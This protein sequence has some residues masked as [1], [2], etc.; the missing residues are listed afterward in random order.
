MNNNKIFDSDNHYYEQE[1]AFTRYVPHSMHD[2]CVKWIYVNNKKRALIGGKLNY[3]IKDPSFEFLAKPGAI[4]KY[5]Y[6]AD[7]NTKTVKDIISSSI[8][9]KNNFSH[10][11][12]LKDKRT[13]IKELN[14][15][16]VIL[17]PTYGLIIE[18]F[19]YHDEEA[20]YCTLNGFNKWIL[21]EWG[22]NNKDI[23]AT[24]C[25][26]LVNKDEA[27]KQ[28]E[29]LLD[30][31]IRIINLAP[32]F[33]PKKDYGVSPFSSH[34]DD[35]WKLVND[36]KIVVGL[37][38]D[39]S[40]NIR[41][42]KF[43]SNESVTSLDLDNN[44]LNVLTSNSN[45][46]DFFANAFTSNFFEKFPQV[47]FVTSESG[48][49][50]VEHLIRKAHLVMNQNKKI[51]HTDPLNYF[52]SNIYVSPFPYEDI[53]K[54]KDL[55]GSDNIVLSTDFPHAEGSCYPEVFL[56]SIKNMSQNDIEKIKYS[57]MNNLLL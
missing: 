5:T 4:Y 12:Y 47:K 55:I 11:F 23:F 40:W 22:F 10:S 30:N 8:D 19:L 37:H 39:D 14:I 50:W 25:I 13:Q 34:Y 7:D 6:G 32:T 16:K 1:D 43:W 52:R 17:Y 33:V 28:L 51:F 29:F 27:I 41:F 20:L 46:H 3:F 15:S 9:H 57:N 49:N 45:F 38:E 35:F 54:L 26:S 21:D 44:K 48:S 18:N 2:R 56:S 31:Q 36:N 53:Y 24:G 42:S